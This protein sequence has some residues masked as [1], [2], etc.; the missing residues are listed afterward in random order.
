MKPKILVTRRIPD[1]G[2]KLLEKKFELEINEENRPLPKEEIMERLEGKEALLC[3][4]TDTIDE[5]LMAAYPDL[6]VISNYAVGY[7]NIDVDF[8]TKQ[9]IP[10]TNTPGCLTDTTADFAF[11]LLMSIA[12]RVVESDKFA[13]AG[14]FEGWAPMLYLGND[15]YK[16][17]LGIIGLGR[18]GHA[19]AKRAHKGFDMEIVYAD[20]RKDEEFEKEYNA[21]QLSKEELLK[22]ADFV[23]LHV[24]LTEETKHMISEKELEMMKETAYIINTSRGPVIDEEALAEALKEKKIAG[25]ALDVF[26][27]EPRIND[28]LKKMDNV[29][30]VPHIASASKDTRG[31]MAEIAATNLINIFEG[32]KPISIVNAEVLK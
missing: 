24:P 11:A 4:L 5:E 7:N 3:L 14:K 9:G 17:K 16:K 21:K 20:T 25:A 15:V 26:E 12:R 13:R 32:K 30:I 1:E 8:A 2:I 23:T 18:I 28:D 31:K 19:I 22:E 6:K 10:V 29:I 27:N